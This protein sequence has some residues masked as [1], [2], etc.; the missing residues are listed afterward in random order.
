M[1]YLFTTYTLSHRDHTINSFVESGHWACRK[2]TYFFLASRPIIQLILRGEL[3]HVLCSSNLQLIVSLLFLSQNWHAYYKLFWRDVLGNLS[4]AHTMFI[5]CNLIKTLAVLAQLQLFYMQV[6]VICN[7]LWWKNTVCEFCDMDNSRH[8]LVGQ[9]WQEFAHC[10][11]G[12][13]IIG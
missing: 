4:K 5:K 9:K 6:H 3:Q 8:T 2:Y 13:M 1:H 10:L 7:I 11:I 12:I